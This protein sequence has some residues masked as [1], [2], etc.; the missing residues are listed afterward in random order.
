ML[1]LSAREEELRLRLKLHSNAVAQM[2]AYLTQARKVPET[3]S[4]ES[5]LG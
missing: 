1:L 2:E 3:S 5:I 4:V